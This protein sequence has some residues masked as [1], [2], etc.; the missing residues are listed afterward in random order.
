MKNTKLAALA[1]LLAATLSGQAQAQ[2][3]LGLRGN[4]L[5]GDG[6]P[7][8]DI[9]GAGLI[10]KYYLS[11]GWFVAATLD[12]YDYDFERPYRTVGLTQDPNVKTIDSNI[13]T[14]ALG[15]AIGRH[16]GDKLGFDWFWSAGVGVGLPKTANISGP[17]D[18]GGTFDLVI[19]AKTEIQI[20]GTLGTTYY[21]SDRWSLTAAA[22]AE[23]HFIDISVVDRNSGATGNVKSQ[24]PLGAYLS[25]NVAF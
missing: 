14:T 17:T 10:G 2:F 25:V 12:I 16:F 18:S 21:L 6:Q 1:L 7:A 19:D 11:D 22:R 3:E 4:V 13:K 20:M 8:N 15:G 24:S 23:H 5:L 9:L